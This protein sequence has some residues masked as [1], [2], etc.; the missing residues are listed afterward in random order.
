MFR[1]D[2]SQRNGLINFQYC[3]PRQ[4][5]SNGLSS[6]RNK[7]HLEKLC[8]YELTYQITSLGFT[9]L[10]EFHIRRTFLGYSIS[11]WMD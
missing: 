4:D 6:D 7:D 5:L 11:K 10:L 9:K 8:P 3:S 1:E 2:C